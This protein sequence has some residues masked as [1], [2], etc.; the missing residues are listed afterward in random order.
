MKL[1]CSCLKWKK[2][3]TALQGEGFTNFSYSIQALSSYFQNDLA[4][5]SLFMWQG[6][7][8]GFCGLY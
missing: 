7:I 8:C 5:L 4:G 6:K 2:C 1:K 3:V